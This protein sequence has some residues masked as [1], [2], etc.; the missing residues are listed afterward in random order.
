MHVRAPIA[1]IHQHSRHKCS[2]FEMQPITVLGYFH[3]FS[4]RYDGG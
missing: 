3:F 4:F 1:A 2:H